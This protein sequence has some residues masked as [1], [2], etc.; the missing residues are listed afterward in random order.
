MPSEAVWRRASYV[1]QSTFGRA[2]DF[3]PFG[4]FSV[5]SAV[6]IIYAVVYLLVALA[7]AIHR[8]QQRDL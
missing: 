1:M 2:M 6:M 4:A 8:F 5:P 7:L 3:T